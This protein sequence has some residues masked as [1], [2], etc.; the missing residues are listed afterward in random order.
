MIRLSLTLPV[1]ALTRPGPPL[2]RHEVWNG[3][4]HKAEHPSAFVPE[5]TACDVVERGPH[6]F[7]R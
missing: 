7:V 4:R 2:S 6:H 3:L 5:I 1:N